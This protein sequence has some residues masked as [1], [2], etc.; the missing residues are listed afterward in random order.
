MK[1]SITLFLSLLWRETNFTLLMRILCSLHFKVT[2]SFKITSVCVNNAYS[3]FNDK[4]QVLKCVIN[5][6]SRH[7]TLNTYCIH[8]VQLQQVMLQWERS[9]PYINLLITLHTVWVTSANLN[10]VIW[11]GLSLQLSHICN[12]LLGLLRLISQSPQALCD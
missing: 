10:E 1:P 11:R 5:T 12:S 4:L 2:L 7:Q 3:S 9:V 6:Y 8:V